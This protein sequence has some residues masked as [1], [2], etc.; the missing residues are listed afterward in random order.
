MTHAE[1][2]ENEHPGKMLRE[3]YLEPLGITPYKLAKGTGL[4]PTHVSE[5]LKGERNIT[6][7]TSLLLGT[8][9]EMSPTFWTNLQ[10]HYDQIEAQRSHPERLAK[11]VSYRQLLAA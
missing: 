8:F 10:I 7:M 9:F 11:A 2:L 5:L 1:L 3:D 4:T 6:I